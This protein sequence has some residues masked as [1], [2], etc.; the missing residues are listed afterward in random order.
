MMTLTDQTFQ[1][2]VRGAPAA[3]VGFYGTACAACRWLTP[4]MEEVAPDYSGRVTFAGFDAHQ[5]FE[6]P[7]ELGIFVVPTLVFFKD[8]NEVGR[9]FRGITKKKL[10]DE[11]RTH[12]G[13]GPSS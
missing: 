6:T 4:V 13:L 10:V 12:L 5:N 3:V 7:G 8:G 1:Q 2:E 11:I 9:V